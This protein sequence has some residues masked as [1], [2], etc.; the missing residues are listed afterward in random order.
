MVVVGEVQR[1]AVVLVFDGD[2]GAVVEEQTHDVDVTAGHRV[3]QR[4]LT[5]GVEAVDGGTWS[6]RER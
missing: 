6:R 5:T 1:R 2:V 4:S 3:M